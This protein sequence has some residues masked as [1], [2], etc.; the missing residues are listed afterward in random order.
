MI[1]TKTAQN[2][3]HNVMKSNQVALLRKRSSA[4][5]VEHRSALFVTDYGF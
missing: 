4:K 5:A 3:L 2:A 1:L